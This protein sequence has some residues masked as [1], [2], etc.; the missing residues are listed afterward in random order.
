MDNGDYIYHSIS[1]LKSL[2]WLGIWALA[3]YLFIPK[4]IHAWE[5][6]KKTKKTIHLSNAVGSMVL[7]FLAY[8]ANFVIMVMKLAGWA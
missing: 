7:A 4:S 2:A 8:S 6:W 5:L 1:I 3:T